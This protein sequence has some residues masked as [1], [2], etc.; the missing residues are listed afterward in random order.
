MVDTEKLQAL[1]DELFDATDE[2]GDGHISHV[3]LLRA[4]RTNDRLRH[5]LGFPSEAEASASAA[6]AGRSAAS[7]RT[8]C[9]EHLWAEMDS[10]ADTTISRTEFGL[11]ILEHH[12]GGTEHERQAEGA[13]EPAPQP[14]PRDQPT[15]LC[16]I[17][18]FRLTLP[19]ACAKPNLV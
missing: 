17:F 9:F 6:A 18:G 5:E 19:E 10:N 12:R 11:W 4:L 1:A 16:T 14:P 3:E 13:P 2:N 15:P 7:I 8:L